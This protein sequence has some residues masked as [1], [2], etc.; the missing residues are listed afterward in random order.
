MGVFEQYSV[1][2][3]QVGDSAVIR[4]PI[5]GQLQQTVGNRLVRHERAYRPG[6][7]LDSTGPAPV[8][9]SFTARF[10]NTIREPGLDNGAPL[11]PDML[12]AFMATLA[13]QRTGTLVLPTVGAIRARIERCQ[14]Q[15]DFA[16]RDEATLQITACE[17]NEDAIATATFALPTAR[18]TISKQAGAT[19]F[20][21]EAAVAAASEDL[22]KLHAATT[23]IETLLL[24]PGRALAD[25]DSQVRQQRF[26]VQRIRIEQD[27]FARDVGIEGT[28]EPR[29]SG[30]FRQLLRLEDTLARA[31]DEKFASRPRI[32]AFVV[33]VPITS[34]FEIAARLKQDA[35]ALLDLNGERVADPFVL[36]QGEVIRVFDAAGP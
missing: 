10:N 31:S 2:S 16:E 29:G 25:L 18:A 4:F 21:A 36:E 26:T 9:V 19:V 7:K 3:W 30:F 23:D 5:T 12:N 13:V 34:L 14:R 33:D 24:A 28:T 8:E 27:A 6:A 15:E 20:S 32:R 1:A 35:A 11:Y 17:D 22:F